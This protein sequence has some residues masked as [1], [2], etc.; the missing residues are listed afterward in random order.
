MNFRVFTLQAVGTNPVPKLFRGVVDS[1]G[2]TIEVVKT[3]NQ[4]TMD[5]VVVP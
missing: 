1:R 2:S 4:E 3:N 5:Y